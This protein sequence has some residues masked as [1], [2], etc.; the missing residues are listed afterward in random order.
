MNATNVASKEKSFS[1]KKKFLYCPASY[2]EKKLEI[3][4]TSFRAIKQSSLQRKKET[5]GYL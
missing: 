5:M 4:E 3:N 1:P 2:E